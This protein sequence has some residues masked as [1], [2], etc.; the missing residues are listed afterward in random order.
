MNDDFFVRID[1]ASFLI[2][3]Y[4]E[5]LET[6]LEKDKL[7]SRYLP[8]I[9][10]IFAILTWGFFGVFKTGKFPFGSSLLN[11]YYL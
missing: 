5:D 2:F 8:I 6:A 9:A 11:A 1:F 10:V 7:R 4:L 3:F